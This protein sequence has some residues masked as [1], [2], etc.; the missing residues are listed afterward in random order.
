MSYRKQSRGKMYFPMRR[1]SVRFII[2]KL[3]PVPKSSGSRQCGEKKAARGGKLRCTQ[4]IVHTAS[5]ER[6]AAAL[7]WSAI[8]KLSFLQIGLRTGREQVSLSG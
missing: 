7:G 2:R 1:F 8:L 5:R 3:A 6:V 4:N